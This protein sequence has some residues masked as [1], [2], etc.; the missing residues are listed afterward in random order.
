[1]NKQP[2]QWLRMAVGILFLIHGIFRVVT[3]I[4]DDFGGFFTAIGWPMGLQLAWTITC[5]EIIC[6][7]ALIIGKWWRIAAT[8]LI[9]QTIAGIYLVHW[10]HGWFV[11]GGG[12]NGMEYSFL[13]IV[14]LLTVIFQIKDDE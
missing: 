5:L 9:T 3:G 8:Y 2:I 13:L 6:A 7:L 10:P 11:V 12:R 4:V 14:C 1:M